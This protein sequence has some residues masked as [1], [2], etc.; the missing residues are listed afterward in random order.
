[1]SVSTGSPR[2]AITQV[3]I[4]DPAAALRFSFSRKALASMATAAARSAH[5]ARVKTKL[6]RGGAGLTFSFASARSESLTLS[7]PLRLRKTVRRGARVHVKVAIVDAAGVRT[8]VA[9]T[10]A[11]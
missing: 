10:L 6:A 2:I 11:L 8:A 1:L 4:A 5:A 7:V 9:L 3:G